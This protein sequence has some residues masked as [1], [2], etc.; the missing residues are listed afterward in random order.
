[1]SQFGPNS[2]TL[3]STSSSH[4]TG[5][6]ARL[7]SNFSL[8]SSGQGFERDWTPDEALRR[9]HEAYR[10]A[11]ASLT[12]YQ[13]NENQ[14][15]REG[16]QRAAELL[17]WLVPDF[18]EDNLSTIAAALYQLA[19]LPAMSRSLTSSRHDIDALAAFVASDFRAFE[20]ASRSLARR[21]FGTDPNE[22]P[23]T[24]DIQ[25]ELSRILL[26]SLNI[27]TA[28][29]RWG[30]DRVPEAIISLDLL[31]S[32]FA[33][34]QD[35]TSWLLSTLIAIIANRYSHNS[36]RRAASGIYEA[37]SQTGQLALERYYRNAYRSGQALAW[38]TQELG[39]K[40]L[41]TPGNFS[42]CTPTGSGK[43][44]IAEIAII[45]ALYPKHP[46]DVFSAQQLALY[47]VPSKALAAEIERRLVQTFAKISEDVRV[48]TSYGGQDVGSS[49]EELIAQIPTVIVCT[50]E[51]CD[52][53]IR[54]AGPLFVNRLRLLII[55][56]AHNVA[57][58]DK[59]IT[60]SL[61]LEGLFARLYSLRSK[62]IRV[63]ALSAVTNSNDQSLGRW[64]SPLNPETLRLSYQS[65]RRI[66]GRLNVSTTGNFLA[67]YDL[68]N[69]ALIGSLNL[70]GD[71]PRVPNLIPRFSH[72]EE[73]SK[74]GAPVGPVVQLRAATLWAGAHFAR[75]DSESSGAVLITVGSKIEQYAKSFLEL[76]DKWTDLPA[77]YR[78]PESQDLTKVFDDAKASCVDYFG[79][80]S[81]E[82]RLLDHGIVVHHGKLPVALQRRF[83]QLID[84]RIVRICLATSTLSEGVNL[85]FET[86]LFPSLSG[87]QGTN[88]F[89]VQEIRN[90]IGRAGRP[91]FAREGR[92]LVLMGTGEQFAL[93]NDR[94]TRALHK[95]TSSN[96]QSNNPQSALASLIL[97]IEK[98]WK[99]RFAGKMTFTE[100]LEST[101]YAD[102]TDEPKHAL[103]ELDAFLIAAQQEL[104]DI[105]GLTNYEMPEYEAALRELWRSTY[106]FA[107]TDEAT[108]SKHTVA[109]IARSRNLSKNISPSD[110][111]KIYRTA[112]VK[113]SAEQLIERLPRLRSVLE[114]ARDFS[115]WTMVQRLQFFESLVSIIFEIPEFD[116]NKYSTRRDPN[117]NDLLAW[118]LKQHN[119]H[120]NEAQ[121]GRWYS[122]AN[123]LFGYRFLWALSSAILCILPEDNL[124]DRPNLEDRLRAAG[125]PL[126]IGWIRDMLIVGLADPVATFCLLSGAATTRDEAQKL[127]QRYYAQYQPDDKLYE[128]SKIIAWRRTLEGHVHR[129]FE[130]QS[131][132][133][134]PVDLVE[135]ITRPTRVFPDDE[136]GKQTT[137]RD[138]S[139]YPIAVSNDAHRLTNL[140]DDDNLWDDHFL[141]PE[142]D[143][144]RETAYLSG[145]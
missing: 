27:V 19:D 119:G 28:G 99:E 2:R 109:I 77:F 6:Q 45:Q 56:E 39:L 78:R 55:D 93:H 116:A 123:K 47:I 4:F 53:L 9:R 136:D 90:V 67:E 134:T 84:A 49:D 72:L 102:L 86:V 120:V 43:T 85:P 111:K 135:C 104:A 138:V 100:W 115:A 5:P 106:A 41:S 145:S 71:R 87:N 35:E 132:T 73:W 15:A 124:D 58:T 103:E 95:L 117:W 46:D 10:I 13:A 24:S 3:L 142:I 89:T 20:K 26:S 69:G 143:V 96:T 17:E 52:A 92:A 98:F 8:R 94:Y 83:T 75:T 107:V 22:F 64:V 57:R 21:V 38:P 139:G 140:S 25:Q 60:R 97:E 66:F 101:S 108:S 80:H 50:Q 16:F 12:A 121:V 74:K 110:R 51:K 44:T 114:T 129:S 141:D 91:G 70:T 63:I 34:S 32:Y 82:A 36:L 76:L 18:P 48:V 122:Q 14:I 112:M 144:V 118:W 105:A 79:S 88:D 54:N 131:A 133:M 113:T 42:L 65:T 33:G 61:R 81:Y 62:N 7:F 130:Y 59:D 11:V 137:W 23:D 30:D 40:R 31:A 29:L 1:M 68:V 127:S 128:R 125:L 126:V 37:L